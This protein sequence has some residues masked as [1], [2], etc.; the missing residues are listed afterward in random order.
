MGLKVG[1]TGITWGIP[2]DPVR[3]YEDTAELGYLGF[4]TFGHTIRGVDFRP[5]I[6]RH[7]IP[8]CA[9]YVSR[10]W[11][12][13]AT[14]AD[15]LE[16]ARQDAEALAALGGEV[17][18]LACN[19][20]PPDGLDAD[21]FERLAE[22]LNEAGRQAAVLGLRAGLHP[23]T[24]THVE[25]A[26]DIE[27]IMALLD[28]AVVGF[29]PD[30]G[31]IAKGGSDAVAVCRRYRDRT[32]HVHLKDWGGSPGP[33]DDTGYAN[34]Q[35]VGSGVLPMS[36]L[37]TL[38]H[39]FDGW[40]NVELDGTASAPRPAREAAAMSRRALGDLLGDRVNWRR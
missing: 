36:E 18:V 3:A 20:R 29:A 9:A 30:T 5:L 14:T 22:A 13:P 16:S 26:D 27:R 11:I 21:G 24:G 38:Y 1:H 2:G 4:E 39:D 34:Y 10:M 25:T 7:G 6:A 8:V 17:V 12:D 33:I 19:R 32:T 15:D 37:L 40:L 35:P 28:P 31:Q 23:H